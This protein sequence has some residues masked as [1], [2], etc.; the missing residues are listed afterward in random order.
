[1]STLPPTLAKLNKQSTEAQIINEIRS[2]LVSCNDIKE[3]ARFGIMD[4][5]KSRSFLIDTNNASNVQ[6]VIELLGGRSNHCKSFS[7]SSVHLKII[8]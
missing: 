8:D 2:I 5:G 6:E 3:I 4:D 1:M 7:I